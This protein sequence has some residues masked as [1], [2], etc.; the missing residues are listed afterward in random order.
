MASKTWGV[1]LAISAVV[2]FLLPAGCA[3]DSRMHPVDLAPAERTG[4]QT[5]L[6]LATIVTSLV[7]ALVI[8]LVR[9]YIVLKNG[10]SDRGWDTFTLFFLLAVVGS[11][12]ARTV[13]M[14]G[15]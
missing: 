7:V 6:I 8:Y 9:R 2:A 15:I 5:Y 12:L 10:K 1:S 4:A 11:I 14:P 3:L 13:P